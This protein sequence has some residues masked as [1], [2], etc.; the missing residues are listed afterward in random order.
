MLQ[1]VVGRDTAPG[2][3]AVLLLTQNGR[4]VKLIIQQIWLKMDNLTSLF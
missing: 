1:G 4:F 2:G 3:P